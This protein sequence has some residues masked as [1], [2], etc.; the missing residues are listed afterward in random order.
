MSYTCRNKTLPRP[1]TLYV[2]KP[3]SKRWYLHH[4][5]YES[6]QLARSKL[7]QCLKPPK[8]NPFA[9]YRNK[10]PNSLKGPNRRQEPDQK[11]NTTRHEKEPKHRTERKTRRGRKHKQNR[12]RH[13]TETKTTGKPDG[14]GPVNRSLFLSAVQVYKWPTMHEDRKYRLK[15]S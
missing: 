4:W 3:L 7:F 10:A 6:P 11:Q 1:L 14:K 8:R 15:C 2:L 9:P 12:G 13:E 5:Q